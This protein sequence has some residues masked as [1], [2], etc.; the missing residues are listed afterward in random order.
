[1]DVVREILRAM[2]IESIDEL[3][4]ND[5][6]TITVQGYDDLTIERIADCQVS[7]AHHYVQR[8]DLMCDPEV[9]FAIDDDQWIP[10]EYTQHPLVHK[11]DKTGLDID[12]FLKR[13]NTNLRNQGFLR[14][15]RNNCNRSE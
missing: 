12:A 14:A 5:P 8:G 7:V 2:N 10:I 3:D 1:M 4:I 6:V 13:W 15:A 9:V 11:Y